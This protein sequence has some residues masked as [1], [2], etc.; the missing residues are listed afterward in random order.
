MEFE[1]IE[2][3]EVVLAAMAEANKIAKERGI[4]DRVE[5]SKIFKDILKKQ[6]NLH[7]INIVGNTENPEEL[8]KNLDKLIN[9]E[10]KDD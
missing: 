4:T 2:Y 3:N 1:F 6:E 5:I 10:K 8:G 7:K 9:K